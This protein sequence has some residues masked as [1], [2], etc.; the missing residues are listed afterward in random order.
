VAREEAA[1]AL[2]GADIAARL[3]QLSIGR[4]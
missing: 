3:A 1:P 2:G 4:P